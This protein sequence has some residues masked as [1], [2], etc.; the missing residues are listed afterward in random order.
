MFRRR[1]ARGRRGG[2]QISFACPEFLPK[3]FSHSLMSK[4][5]YPDPNDRRADWWQN[6]VQDQRFC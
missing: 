4:N 2:V 3:Y 1:G 6:I 5:Y